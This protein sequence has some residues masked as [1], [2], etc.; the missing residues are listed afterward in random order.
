MKHLILY[1]LCIIAIISLNACKKQQNKPTQLG[2]I[3]IY[4]LQKDTNNITQIVINGIL[5]IN[6][7]QYIDNF[8][9]DGHYIIEN[10]PID[11][12]NCNIK[13]K[14]TS[15]IHAGEYRNDSII[16]NLNINSIYSNT[17]IIK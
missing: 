10:L 14:I 16:A 13:G 3:D 2:K 7:N 5:S 17:I 6:N 8:T 1:I 4:L 11:T 9:G 15:G 12:Y